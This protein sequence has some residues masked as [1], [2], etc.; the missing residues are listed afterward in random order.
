MKS[1]KKLILGI[2]MLAIV[3]T[4]AIIAAVAIHGLS[5]QPPTDDNL[6]F[7]DDQVVPSRIYTDGDGNKI[8]LKYVHSCE[9]L[10][11]GKIHYYIDSDSNE[12]SYND[13][14]EFISLTPNTAKT[15]EKTQQTYT[16]NDS[17]SSP[18]DEMIKLASEY[19]RQ[20]Y[21]EEY[22][23][24][25]QFDEI[26]YREDVSEYNICF[27]VCYQEFIEGEICS[28]ILKKDGSLVKTYVWSKGEFEEFD[29]HMLNG[30]S[31]SALTE[32]AQQQLQK[33]Y[34]DTLSQHEIRGF[35]LS[36]DENGKYRISIPI[37]L[38]FKDETISPTTVTYY[39][40][41]K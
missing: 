37:S 10:D 29:P 39:Y 40:G 15:K 35:Y 14:S 1:K 20:A 32:F 34:A 36:K 22:F 33:E 41:L 19:A 8:A 12:Y 26:V 7:I 6:Y 27:H 21:G 3:L 17:T 31:K 9:Q 18:E 4:T 23:S 2:S 30:I 11:G 16:L 25:F 5:Q 13:A 24:R 28:I 38:T